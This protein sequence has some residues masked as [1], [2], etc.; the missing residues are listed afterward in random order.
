MNCWEICIAKRQRK[1]ECDGLDKTITVDAQKH[2]EEMVE[3][4]KT[5]EYWSREFGKYQ[6]A[7]T[8][9]IHA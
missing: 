2:Y 4:Q 3:K 7:S 9:E 1:I 8:R 6:S 5:Q